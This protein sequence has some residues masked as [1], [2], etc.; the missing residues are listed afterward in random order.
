MRSSF[1][2]V[3]LFFGVVTLPL[4]A[5]DPPARVSSDERKQ[6]DEIVTGYRRA[7]EQAA[8]LSQIDK[9]AEAGAFALSAV[10]ELVSRELQGVLQRYRGQVS[11]AATQAYAKRLDKDAVPEI[12]SLRKKV[13]DQVHG[14]G[15]LTKQMIQNVSDPA[16]ERLR[17]MILLERSAV[18]D[19]NPSLLKLREGLAP[20]GERWQR[21]RD[22]QTRLDNEALRSESSKTE[23]KPAAT[24]MTFDGYLAADED[25]VIGLALPLPVEMRAVFITNASYEGKIDPEEYRCIMALNLTRMLLGLNCLQIDPNL[26]LCARDHSHDMAEHKFFSHESPLSNKKSFG[27]RAKNFNTDA[28]AENIANGASDGIRTHRQWWH[29]PGHHKNLLGDYKRVGVGRHQRLWTE[30]LGR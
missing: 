10:D 1:V 6:A 26:V 18:I 16:L 11:R 29:S 14:D 8:K 4:T 23:A 13:L 19:A 30:M 3:V 2:V 17:E 27:D 20:F 21:V 28:G 22:H 7:K 12:E 9:A 15:E 24:V 25:Q 5:A